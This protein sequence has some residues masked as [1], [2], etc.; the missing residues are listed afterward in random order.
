MK[1]TKDEFGQLVTD[2]VAKATA[3]MIEDNAKTRER[4]TAIEKNGKALIPPTAEDCV[5]PS[6]PGTA[7]DPMEKLF[8]Q[9]IREAQDKAP[10]DLPPPDKFSI[11]RFLKAQVQRN[12][13]LAPYE[14]RCM[15][16]T[17]EKFAGLQEKAIAWASGSAGGY[18]VG[19]EFLPEEFIAVYRSAM[20]CRQAGM[21]ILPCT[22][23]PVLI[24][25][26]TAGGT[27]YWLAQNGSITES[28]PTP[29]QLSLSPK[30]AA[31]R[32]QLS[33]FL[34]NTSAGAAEQIVREDMANA[35]AAAVDKACIEGLP[36]TASPCP[37]GMANASSINNVDIGT[38][39]GVITQALLD[40]MI[41]ELD[42]DNV[43]QD[44]RAF[45]MHPRT[46]HNITQLIVAS[47][48]NNFLYN[49]QSGI[50]GNIQM[51]PLK[52]IRGIPVYLSTNVSIAETKGSG[53]ALANLV[54][55][56]MTDMMLAEWG[57]VELAATDTGGNAWAQN[58]IEIRATYSCDFG[59]RNPNSI[60]LIDDTTS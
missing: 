17:A 32:V 24:P 60:C 14:F 12:P 21:R 13:A 3:P 41:L 37:T 56:R 49:P 47:E 23:A 43:P 18:W 55:A 22:G 29:G 54:L 58:S 26:A 4:V 48:A 11:I 7:C 34:V 2:A 28:S 36:T 6:L 8:E 59:A 45:I 39:G 30:F 33:K 35:L 10:S 20:V 42:L 52:Q 50:P 44:G 46:W 38:N 40:D 19:T 5:P 51:A 25:K 1:L 53:T 15:Q 31:H 16:K 9:R 57:G 27:V